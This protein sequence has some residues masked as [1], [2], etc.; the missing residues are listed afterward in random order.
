M[1]VTSQRWHTRV[2]HQLGDRLR[3]F[4][5]GGNL[6][7]GPAQGFTGDR[8]EVDRDRLATENGSNPEPRTTCRL[9]LPINLVP[10]DRRWAIWPS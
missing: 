2:R 6:F 5:I 7:R 3:N 8:R 4:S 10:E 1:I 9:G